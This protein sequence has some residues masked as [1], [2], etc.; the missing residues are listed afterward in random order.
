M[1]AMASER[2]FEYDQNGRALRAAHG[3]G[4]EAAF[5]YSVTRKHFVCIAL[6]LAAGLLAAMYFVGGAPARQQLVYV[7]CEDKRVY[8]VDLASGEVV[9]RS[10]PIEG[11][12]RPTSVVFVS[13]TFRL[14][15]GSQWNYPQEG[16]YP[17]VAVDVSDG[18]DVVGRYTLDPEQDAIDPST[19]KYAD[20][21]FR[22][23]ASET[24]NHLYLMYASLDYGGGV[25]AIF[26]MAA[27]RIVGKT[28]TTVM[29]NIVFSP[30]GSQKAEIWASSSRTIDGVTTEFP[31]GVAVRDIMT[32][33]YISR[34]D[35][36]G[37]RGL[38]PPWER[39]SSPHLD[40]V[41]RTE[42]FRLYDRDSGSVVSTMDLNEL[43]GMNR[44]QGEPVLIEGSTHMIAPMHMVPS[45][46]DS[47]GLW[48]APGFLVVFDYASGEV[49][50]TI[51]VG[52]NPTT[53]AF[54][55]QA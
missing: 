23:V 40:P 33:E 9:A 30:D 11:M 37:N 24:A 45:G 29:P 13:E 44:T 5:R 36:D 42:T 43:T 12:G 26:D 15:I 53:V 32:G 21:V 51:E 38:Q 7:A 35:L 22:V 46:E 47:P 19:P 8:A 55:Q 39:L 20:P 6:V 4:R 1:L 16:Y 25:A 52:P 14:Y 41:G 34:V 3:N 2:V 49:V 10:N 50:K 18:F 31:G 17:L 54:H 48:T 27:E 28:G